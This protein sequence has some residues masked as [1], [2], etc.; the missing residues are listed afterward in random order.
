MTRYSRSVIPGRSHGET[1]NPGDIDRLVFGRKPAANDADDVAEI[2]V[3]GLVDRA[4][5]D[6]R[7]GPRRRSDF[8]PLPEEKKAYRQSLDSKRG[9]LLLI[10]AIVIVGVFGVV[11]WNAYRDGVRPEDSA[12][13]PPIITPSGAFKSKPASAA[14]SEPV[15]QASV[16]DQVEGPKAVASSTPEVRSEPAVEAPLVTAAATP[17]PAPVK[18]QVAAAPEPLKS[19]A[20]VVLAP[21]PAEAKPAAPKPLE[22]KPVE[23][24]P[25]APELAGA[26]KP[27]FSPGGKYVVQIAAPS[28]E[29][30][31]LSEW[32]K[33]AK[34]L[35]E[36]FSTA[37]RV[38]IKAD[39]NGRTVYRLRAG[40][41]ATGADADAFCAAYQARGGACFKTTR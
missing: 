33:R 39:V 10:G 12:V 34:A 25:A 38:V 18:S 35:P 22:S 37:E 14:Q 2:E 29:A 17:A 27:A 4:P 6:R 3:S 19:D 13:A 20:P 31:A 1:A 30:A 28:T 8:A 40:A 7:R 36:L 41:F 16:F 5:S 24:K 23:P 21:K 32:D 11:V 9:P 26:F 15:E